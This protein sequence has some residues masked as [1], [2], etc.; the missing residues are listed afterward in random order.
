[1]F[2]KQDDTTEDAVRAV[3]KVRVKRF[4]NELRN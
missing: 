3:D 2:G 4:E 1:M